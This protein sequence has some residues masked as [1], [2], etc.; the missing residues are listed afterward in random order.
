MTKPDYLSPDSS[1]GRRQDLA[2]IPDGGGWA[3]RCKQQADYFDDFAGPRQKVRASHLIEVGAEVQARR[4]RH[5]RVRIS[6]T[7]PRSISRS[8]VSTEASSAPLPIS[9]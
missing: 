3:A 4:G 1:P 8:W 7:S 5:E 2:K 6:S 9:K